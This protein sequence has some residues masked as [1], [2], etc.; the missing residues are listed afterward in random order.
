MARELK[1]PYGDLPQQAAQPAQQAAQAQ[2]AAPDPGLAQDAL[3]NQIVGMVLQRVNVQ[4]AQGQQPAAPADVL[5]A[6]AQAMLRP[7]PLG[8]EALKAVA[9]YQALSRALTHN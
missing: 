7:S 1:P 6:F 2:Q 5:A 9:K 3:V 4:V 8:E